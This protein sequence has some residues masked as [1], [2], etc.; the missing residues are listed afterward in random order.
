MKMLK[1]R[2]KDLKR[3]R[4]FPFLFLVTWALRSSLERQAEFRDACPVASNDFK[5]PRSSTLS[6]TQNWSGEN[7]GRGGVGQE[8]AKEENERRE[9]PQPSSPASPLRSSGE[10]E[11]RALRWAKFVPPAS[12][13]WWRGEEGSGAPSL[14]PRERLRP[15]RAYLAV[16]VLDV[17]RQFPK[18]FHGSA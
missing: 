6:H 4:G 3:E 13:S 12:R 5:N 18:H 16:L 2:D 17:V 9:R 7:R 14:Q 8:A 11:R 15:R 10:S 1:I